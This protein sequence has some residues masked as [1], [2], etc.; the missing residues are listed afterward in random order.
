MQTSRAVFDSH[1]LKTAAFARMFEK[2]SVV[3]ASMDS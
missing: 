3:A 2:V 1:F